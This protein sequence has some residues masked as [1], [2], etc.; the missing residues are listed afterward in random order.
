[1]KTRDHPPV[2][3]RAKGKT[4]TS[5]LEHLKGDQLEVAESLRALVM[6]CLPHA[7]ETST[8]GNITYLLND[9]NLAWL[10]FYRDHTDFGF[11]RGVDLESP[12]LEGTGKG[13]RHVKVLSMDD[14]DENEF[15]R[16]LLDA[17]KL[18]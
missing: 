8:W 5:V 16:L 10:C 11:F 12:R 17:A 6:K 4:V 7:V 2:D 3:S 9:R 15:R 13:L 18:T 14:I 1:M